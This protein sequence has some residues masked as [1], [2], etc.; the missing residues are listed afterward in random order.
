MPIYGVAELALALAVTAC[1]HCC[2]AARGPRV[3]VSACHDSRRGGSE[4]RTPFQWTAV[5]LECRGAVRANSPPRQISIG[6]K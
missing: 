3:A 4:L 1:Q 6:L 2:P 5:G